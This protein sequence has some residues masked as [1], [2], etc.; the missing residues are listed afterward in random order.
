MAGGAGPGVRA[1]RGAGRHLPARFA[2]AL[3]NDLDT[4]AAIRE[5]RAAVRR[6]DQTG[7]RQ[8]LPILVGTASLS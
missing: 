6:G 4:P 5:L 3:A 7:V 1:A 8:M 2:A